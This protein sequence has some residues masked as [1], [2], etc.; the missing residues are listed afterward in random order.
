ME[1]TQ[2]HTQLMYVSNAILEHEYPLRVIRMSRRVVLHQ[3][4]CSQ[5]QHTKKIWTQSDLRFCENGSK[6]SKINEKGGRSIE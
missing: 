2:H 3:I 6:G 4:F 1:T 5:I